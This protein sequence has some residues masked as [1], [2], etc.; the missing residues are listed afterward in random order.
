MFSPVAWIKC[1]QLMFLQTT[2]IYT[3]DTIWTFLQNVTCHV[4]ITCLC[5]H[6][7]ITRWR[8]RWWNYRWEFFPASEQYLRLNF[9]ICKC[10]TTEYLWGGGGRIFRCVCRD[11]IQ[12]F[13][14][15]SWDIFRHFKPKHDVFLYQVVVVTK[16]KQVTCTA[17][18]Q[19]N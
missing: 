13:P 16:N 7:R 4:H 10:D 18:S 6:S 11:K 2:D 15:G 8:T 14:I 3:T 9:N 17:P 1:W 5:P 12:I 19:I